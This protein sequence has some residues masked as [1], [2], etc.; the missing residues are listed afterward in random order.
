ME[1]WKKV[2]REGLVPLLSTDGLEALRQALVRDDPRLIQQA[3]SNPP[4]AE[5]FQDEAC[6]GACALGYC[7]W[8]GDGFD[9][10]G[11]VETFFIRTCRMADE[12]LGEP[13]ACRFFLNWFDDTPRS[14]MRRHLLQEINWALNQRYANAA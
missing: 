4:P 5:V 9:T 6:E 10:V 14:E 12:A 13:A 8:R 2:W 1:S 7:G 11:E 3:T